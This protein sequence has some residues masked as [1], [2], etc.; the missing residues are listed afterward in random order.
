MNPE[1]REALE[2]L[3]TITLAALLLWGPVFAKLVLDAP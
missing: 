1:T 2:I 3:G